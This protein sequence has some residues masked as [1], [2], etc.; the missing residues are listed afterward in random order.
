MREVIVTAV[1][2][3]KTNNKA[4]AVEVV[5]KHLFRENS[6]VRKVKQIIIKATDRNVKDK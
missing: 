6:D 5:Q 1:I 3:V 4:R 2:H